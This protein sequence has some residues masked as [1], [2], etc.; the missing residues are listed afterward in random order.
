MGPFVENFVFS[1]ASAPLSGAAATTRPASTK[2]HTRTLIVGRSFM[3][4]SL[5]SYSRARVCLSTATGYKTGRANSIQ[6][7]LITTTLFLPPVSAEAS[8]RQ[9]D[10]A[11]VVTATAFFTTESTEGTEGNGRQH[12]RRTCLAGLIEHAVAGK[13]GLA[14]ERSAGACPLF[15]PPTH[16]PE[17]W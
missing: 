7:R 4:L 8:T 9:A 11:D 10:S 13:W 5:S 3:L 1:G 2:R 14:P 17:E 16:S 6:V 12:L 15:P